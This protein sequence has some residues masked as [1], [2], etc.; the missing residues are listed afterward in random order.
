MAKQKSDEGY[1]KFKEDI[2]SG[3]IG[4]CYI[5][6]GEEDYLRDY[7]LQ[8]LEKK[9]VAEDFR[10]FNYAVFEGSKLDLNELESAVDSLPMLS[11]RKLLVVKDY[12]LYSGDEKEREKIGKLIEGLP[13]YVCLVFVYDTIDYKSDGR[14]K[15]PTQAIKKNALVVD[16]QRQGGSEM[17]SWVRRR[18][19][20]QGHDIDTRTT[21]YLIFICGGLMTNL[22][23]EIEKISA[24]AEHEIIT[25]EDI[26]AVAT[27]TV[28]AV[29][30]DLT[31]SIAAGDAD[32][33]MC[34]LGK[35]FMLRE[36]PA[37]ILAVV[38][39]QL[40][41]MYLVRLARDNG[42]GLADMTAMLGY[43]SDYPTR[44]LLTA[45]EKCTADWLRMCLK[46]CA[47]LDVG[48]KSVTMDKEAALEMFVMKL[49]ESRK[50]Q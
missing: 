30:F 41:S 19:K 1:R 14:L 31:D 34:T 32:K 33:A 21:E 9:L 25:R 27:P 23:G 8:Q 26:D 12:D 18:F 22:V 48:L 24:Y 5:L 50:S 4:L 47:E 49:F 35:L 20:S 7:Y 6:H 2:K 15:Y 42:T 17:M 3:E 16:F 46:L 45:V 29:V 36:I 44:R 28:E 40:R 39:S 43:S 37:K 38:G 10:E 11:A 13:E